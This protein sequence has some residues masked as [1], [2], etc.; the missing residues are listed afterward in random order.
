MGINLN[1]YMYKII[2]SARN[3]GLNPENVVRE[4]FQKLILYALAYSNLDDYYIFQGGT[5]LRIFYNSPRVSL[6]MDYTLV[7]R[8]LNKS[9]RDF[10]KVK[11]V[12][13][14]ILLSEGIDVEK[15]S[16][17]IIK[18]FY[19]CFLV[20]NTMNFLEKKIRVKIEV[21][22]RRY[23]DISFGRRI[24]D[25]EYPFK[26]SVGVLVKTSSQ[27][28]VDKISSLAGGVHRNYIRWRDIFDIYWL[29][30]KFNA[31][32]DKKYLKQEFG[33][34]VEGVADLESL[35]KKL[36]EEKIYS[37]MKR[38][39]HGILPPS[40]LHKDLVKKYVSL[41]SKMILKVLGELKNED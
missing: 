3:S 7:S 37:E 22:E 26:T 19:R 31:D 23:I 2:K 25:I 38:E 32:I 10:T 13:K 17:K 36:S 20:F 28:L 5:A 21:I 16:E 30:A 40:L 41:T 4:I 34:W 11:N 29:V 14:K 15:K 8:D 27:L 12:V 24:L 9:I 39:L 33:S 6:D 18:D 1:K 35:L